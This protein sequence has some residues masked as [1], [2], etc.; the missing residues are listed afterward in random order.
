M[1]N[2]LRNLPSV[3]AHFFT[4]PDQQAIAEGLKN[5]SGK[6]TLASLRAALADAETTPVQ[7]DVIKAM[8]E[9]VK[10][11]AP[12]GTLKGTDVRVEQAQG[13]DGVKPVESKEH[14][15]LS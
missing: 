11:P 2:L 4:A 1:T 3:D 14:A 10:N 7:A 12:E 9:A 5:K 8:L 13:A 6:V 15:I